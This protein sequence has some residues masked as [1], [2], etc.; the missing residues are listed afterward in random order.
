MF[1]INLLLCLVGPNPK[2]AE[3]LVEEA[4]KRRTTDNVTAMVVYL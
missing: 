2:I 4:L 1:W 3:M